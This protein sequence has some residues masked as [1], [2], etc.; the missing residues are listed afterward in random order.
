MMNTRTATRF[1]VAGLV[2]V[3]APAS[4]HAAIVGHWALDDPAGTSGTGA[5]VDSQHARNGITIG[6]PTFG[7]G[8]ANANTGTSAS[9]PGTTHI[10][11]PYSPDLNPASFTATAWIY[12]TGGTGHRSPLTSRNGGGGGQGY[13]LYINPGN[14]WD[15]W[16][17]NGPTASD[18]HELAG[19]AVAFNAWSHLA[20]SFD[21]A[22]NTK[23]IYVNGNPT[24]SAVGPN[25]APNTVDDLHI[26]SGGDTGTQ[27]VFAGAVDDVV[28]FNEALDQTAINNVMNNSV[29]DPDLLSAGK[30]YAYGLN[31]PG[32]DAGPYYFDDAHVQTLGAYDTGDVTDGAYYGDGTAP[33]SGPNALLGWGKPVTTP[34]DITIDLESLHTITGV[35]VGSHTWSASANGSPDDVTLSFSTDGT[36]FGSPITQGFFDP[37]TNGQNDFV[38][39]VPGTEAR[40]VKLSFDGGALGPHGSPNKWMLTEVSVHGQAVPSVIP[41]PVTMAAIALALSGLGGYLRKRRQA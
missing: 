9:F 1:L 7:G 21:A 13:I 11:V 14:Q 6:S 10:D 40:Y 33:A 19:G 23:T 37:A 39:N 2:A 18:W 3:L 35:T 12:P 4:L 28:L 25:Y 15:F 17:G 36:T 27:Y 5:V 8:G 26:G 24:N 34:T 20:I 31:L 16:T 30:E 22:T 32:Y 38:V 29:P 41:E